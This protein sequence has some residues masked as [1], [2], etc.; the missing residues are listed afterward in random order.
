M[1]FILDKQYKANQLINESNI[2]ICTDSVCLCLNV[3]WKQHSD[4]EK[5]DS[6]RTAVCVV[7]WKTWSFCFAWLHQ[8]MATQSRPH[9]TLATP[10]PPSTQTPSHPPAAPPACCLRLQKTNQRGDSTAGMDGEIGRRMGRGTSARRVCT[11]RHV[12]TFPP[13]PP[14]PNYFYFGTLRPTKHRAGADRSAMYK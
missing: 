11:F 4:R 13:F 9:T 7:I 10:P 1:A 12:F 2:H 3:P 6:I 5:S 14:C 8:R